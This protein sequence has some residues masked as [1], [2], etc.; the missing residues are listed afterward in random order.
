MAENM[1]KQSKILKQPH[2]RNKKRKSKHPG[3]EKQKSL[4]TQASC[5]READWKLVN[6]TQARCLRSQGF[7][8]SFARKKGKEKYA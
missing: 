7:C 3:E 2:C 4:G 8:G 1:G 5:L 6:Q